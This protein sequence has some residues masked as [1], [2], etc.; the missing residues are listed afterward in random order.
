MDED[1]GQG[2]AENKPAEEKPVE[3]KHEPKH[4]QK[5]EVKHEIKQ[6]KKEEPRKRFSASEWYDKHYKKLLLIAVLLFVLS[7]GYIIFFYVQHG[8]IMNKDVTLTGGTTITV[9]KSD[10]NMAELES[11][12]KGK[13]GEDVIVRKL[14]DITTRRTIAIVVE[15]RAEANS[16]KIAIEDYLK[17]KLDDTNSS[18]EISGTT[19]AKSFYNQLLIAMAIAFVFMAVVVFLVFRTFIP[20]IAVI[21]AGATDILGA[22]VLVDIFGVRVST[23]GIAAFLMLIGY[24]VD[25]DIMLTVKTIRR[26]GEGT[27]NSRIN[28]AFKTGL[29]MTLAALVS[30]LIAHFIS[31]ASVIKEIFLILSFGLFMDLLTTWLGNAAI[32]KWYCEKKKI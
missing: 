10:I 31:A 6:E 7:V 11:A 26:R 27:V 15:T 18:T 29:V 13:L 30:S 32:L 8:D 1:T 17:Y 20:S 12:L 21:F 22:L 23:A 19:L 5:Q 4:E 28:S 14:E 3:I 16:T 9:Y 24:S 2:A 25:T